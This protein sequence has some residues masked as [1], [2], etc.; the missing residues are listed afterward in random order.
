MIDKQSLIEDLVR[1][2]P[3]AVRFLME[4]GVRCLACGEPVWGTLESAA[5]EKGF[6]VEEID[7]L[8]EDLR[9]AVLKRKGQ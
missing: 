1:E 8:V 9:A 6:T 3:V 2:Y 5:R 7:R 4:R